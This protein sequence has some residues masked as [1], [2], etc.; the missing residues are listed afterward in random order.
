V[1]EAKAAVEVGLYKLNPE[2][3]RRLVSTLEPIE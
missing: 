3:E 2:L 1:E